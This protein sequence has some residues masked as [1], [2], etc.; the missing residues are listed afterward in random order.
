MSKPLTFTTAEVEKISALVIQKM[1][2][3]IP[4]IIQASINEVVETRLG[5]KSTERTKARILQALKTAPDHAAVLPPEAAR[6]LVHYAATKTDLRRIIGNSCTGFDNA[7]EGLVQD[8][9]IEHTQA[10]GA[11]GRLLQIYAIT[12]KGKHAS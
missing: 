4:E 8:K 3:V 6:F 11:K 5:T 7:V 12:T 2:R 9:L 1:T 10:I